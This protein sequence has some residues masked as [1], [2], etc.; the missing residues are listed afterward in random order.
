L[1][2]RVELVLKGASGRVHLMKALR[3]TWKGS[4]RY[5]VVFFAIALVAAIFGFTGIAGTA[6]SIAKVLFFVFLV[7][8]IASWIEGNR[9][10]RV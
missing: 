10:R 5:A 6:I 9:R 1:F 4:M 2:E 8:A 7:L 3:F